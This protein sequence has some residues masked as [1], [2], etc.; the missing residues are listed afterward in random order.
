MFTVLIWLTLSILVGIYAKSKGKSLIG[1]ILIA[2]I[3]SPLIGFIIALI[4]SPDEEFIMEKDGLMKCSHCK[5]LIKKDATVCKF[6]NNDPKL[7]P[8]NNKFVTK[9]FNNNTYTIELTNATDKDFKGIKADLKKQ[10]F[11]HGYKSTIDKDELYSLKNS[12]NE[13]TYIQISMKNEKIKVE[14]YNVPEEPN[15]FMKKEKSKNKIPDTY[16]NISIADELQKLK[17]LLDDEIL[18]KEEFE[19][20]KNKL[21]NK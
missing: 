8:F 1:Y 16:P 3:L 12:S 17:S 20:Q 15:I 21:L 4:V 2:A 13:A 5:G 9:S 6:C 10:Y 7:I 19:E 11:V 18:T 14:A